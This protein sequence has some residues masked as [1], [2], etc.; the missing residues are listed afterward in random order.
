MA[1]LEPPRRERATKGR[2]RG[3]LADPNNGSELSAQL[4]PRLAGQG[5]ASPQKDYSAQAVKWDGRNARCEEGG[6]G[7]CGAFVASKS[8]RS[9]GAGF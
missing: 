1:H 2:G 4:R 3:S 6:T 7:H 8:A 9:G 5:P